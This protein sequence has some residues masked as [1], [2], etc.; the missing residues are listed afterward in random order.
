MFDSLADVPAGQRVVIDAIDGP[1]RTRLEELG[2]AAGVSVDVVQTIAM[3][4]PVI[5]DRQG[6]V[7]AVRRADAASIRVREVAP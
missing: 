6:F 3:G 5:L 2:L 7:F 4:G 1:L